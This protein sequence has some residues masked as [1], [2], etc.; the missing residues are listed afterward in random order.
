VLDLRLCTPWPRRSLCG[1]VGRQVI[2]AQRY[3]VH[4]WIVEWREFEQIKAHLGPDT[5][6]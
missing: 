6:R 3:L 1:L 5:R 2:S 4:A